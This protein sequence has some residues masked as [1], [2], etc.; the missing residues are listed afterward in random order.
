MWLVPLPN[1]GRGHSIMGAEPLCAAGSLSS[2]SLEG[3]FLPISFLCQMC[4]IH[5]HCSGAS[6]AVF[7][8]VVTCAVLVGQTHTVGTLVLFSGSEGGHEET[9]TPS[10][11]PPVLPGVCQSVQ[12]RKAKHGVPR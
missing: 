1:A 2:V 10:F 4:I 3:T 12:G 11:Q 8:R 6:G 5:E 7:T 9:C